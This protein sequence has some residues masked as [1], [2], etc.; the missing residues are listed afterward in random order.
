M[1]DL[2]IIKERVCYET[3]VSE[4]SI[5]TKSRQRDIVLSRYIIYYLAYI[6]TDISL[7]RIGS[8]IG[9]KNHATV[10]HGVNK[11]KDY[12]SYDIKLQ[13]KIDKLE[14]QILPYITGKDIETETIKMQGY[15][16]I[17]NYSKGFLR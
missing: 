14:R 5:S 15:S 13:N 1:K 7:M 17:Y 2:Q 8:Y 11:V 12:L 10:L 4:N 3:G 9:S 16:L 6:N